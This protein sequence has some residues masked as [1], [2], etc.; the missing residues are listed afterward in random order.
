METSGLEVTFRNVPDT[1][2][3]NHFVKVLLSRLQQEATSKL[4]KT[5]DVVCTNWDEASGTARLKVRLLFVQ[6]FSIVASASTDNV[7]ALQVPSRHYLSALRKIKKYIY[8][9]RILSVQLPN[10]SVCVKF[11][12]IPEDTFD[13]VLHQFQFLHLILAG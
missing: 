9:E 7:C 11:G 2:T 10:L 5:E 1:F 13:E 8:D 4:P 12:N 6:P 3:E